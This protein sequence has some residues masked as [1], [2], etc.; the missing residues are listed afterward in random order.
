MNSYPRLPHSDRKF[1][2]SLHTARG[3]ETA[4]CFIAE[5]RKLCAELLISS[6]H[7]EAIVLDDAA[8][9]DELLLAAEFS[10]QG[11][12]VFSVGSSDFTGLCDARTPQSIVAVVEYPENRSNTDGNIVVLDGIADPGNVGT[13]IRTADWFG[14]RTVLLGEGCADRFN[15]KVVRATM[16]SIFRCDVRET[17]DL[18]VTLV[19]D[20]GG[21]HLYGA[22]LGGD[23][24]LEH[25]APQAPFGIVLGNEARGISSAVYALLSQ[26]FFISGGGA[27]SLNVAVAAGIALYQFSAARL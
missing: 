15:P 2:R 12:P 25:C 13:I 17:Q 19:Q 8:G 23:I 3:R 16:G 1:I 10:Q 7:A 22:T 4:Q 21:F 5:G 11:T 18:A 26:T 27:E 6:F 20:F 14:F 9:E 24:A